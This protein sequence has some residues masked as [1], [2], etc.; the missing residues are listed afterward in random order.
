MGYI[1]QK[2]IASV[3]Y[4]Y[5]SQTSDNFYSFISNFQH[6]LSDINKCKPS[7]YVITGHFNV[8]Y[9]SW[10]SNG[11]DTTEGLKL[12]TLTSLNGFDQLINEPHIYKQK[13]LPVLV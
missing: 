5:A 10:W 12:Y 4:R 9:S 11:I 8:R 1:N 13:T 2:V 6:L 7:L 3:I